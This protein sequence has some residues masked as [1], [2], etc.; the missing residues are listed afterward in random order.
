MIESWRNEWKDSFPFL[1][2]Q[3]SSY[4]GQQSS[5]EGSNWAELREAQTMT[6]SLPNTGMA[7]TTDI[8]NA[9][10]IHPKNKQDVGKRLGCN[11]F[12]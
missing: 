10:D 5:N 4:G 1:F 9:D 12:K 7:V 6:L 8:G 2:V 11:C 3:L